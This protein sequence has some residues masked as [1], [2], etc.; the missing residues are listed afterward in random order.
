MWPIA[1]SDASVYSTA[2][3]LTKDRYKRP[4][5]S[6]RHGMYEF[7]LLYPERVADDTIRGFIYQILW[8]VQRWL[9]LPQDEVLLCE[10]DED[11]DRCLFDGKRLL[12]TE[13]NQFKDLSKSI[14]ARNEAVYESIFNFLSSF[15]FHHQ[16]GRRCHFVFTT[17][18]SASTQQKTPE[19]SIDILAAWKKIGLTSPVEDINSLKDAIKGLTSK[20]V[21]K[22][23]SKKDGKLD[24][25]KKIRIT[26]AVDYL[27]KNSLWHPFLSSVSWN[28]QAPDGKLLRADINR[29]LIMHPSLRAASEPVL[30]LFAAR[31]QVEIFHKCANSNPFDRTLIA[32]ER[33]Q[34]LGRSVN[35][36]KLWAQD[37]GLEQLAKEIDL[38]K[39]KFS[40]LQIDFSEIRSRLPPSLKDITD[41]SVKHLARRAEFRIGTDLIRIKRTIYSCIMSW[42]MD[43]HS[44]IVGDPG[45]GKSAVLYQLALMLQAA[46]HDVVVMTVLKF[47]DHFKLADE[48]AQWKGDN[49]GFVLID[50]L[51]AQR[52]QRESLYEAL[53]A[54]IHASPRFHVVVSIRR[55]DLE[56]DLRIQRLFA[57]VPHETYHPSERKRGQDIC[58]VRCFEIRNLDDSE[59]AEVRTQAPMLEAVIQCAGTQLLSLL[60][61]PFNLSIVSQLLSNGMAPESFRSVNTQVKLLDEYWKLR[62]SED[63]V[64]LRTSREALVRSICDGMMKIPDLRL[65]QSA[66][67][68]NPHLDRV[69]DI[70]RAGLLYKSD[71]GFL[72]FNHNII[73]DYAISKYWL[74]GIVIPLDRSIDCQELQA[75]LEQEGDLAMVIYPSLE[76]YFV[77]LW[78]RDLSRHIFWQC[79]ITL[80]ESPLIWPVL[81][82]AP[83][84]VASRLIGRLS[85]IEPLQ[86]ASDSK[87]ISANQTLQRLVSALRNLSPEE[88][89]L[90]G[91]TKRH[92][93]EL[94]RWLSARS[95]P[96]FLDAARRLLLMLTPI[97]T[98][99]SHQY[100]SQIMISAT[101][102]ENQL[103]THQAALAYFDYI[104]GINPPNIELL[105]FSIRILC[106]NAAPHPDAVAVRLRGILAPRMLASYGY[107][108]IPSL[109]RSL[110]WL[111][112]E[113]SSIV[114]EIYT[115][116]FQH[117]GK[118]SEEP[119]RRGGP[120]FGM[121]TN[122]QQDYEGGLHLLKERFG[123]LLQTNPT[124]AT[125][126]LI[127]V[128][129]QRWQA[130]QEREMAFW[131]S[132]DSNLPEPLSEPSEETHTSSPVPAASDE[133]SA[134]QTI[135]HG[136][137][138]TATEPGGTTKLATP[139][140]G[141]PAEPAASAGGPSPAA[142]PARPETPKT[143]AELTSG[144][145]TELV[146]T[147]GDVDLGASAIGS[148]ATPAAPAEFTSSANPAAP[149]VVNETVQSAGAEN[150]VSHGEAVVSEK[151]A[152]SAAPAEVTPGELNQTANLHDSELTGPAQGAGGLVTSSDADSAAAGE[153]TLAESAKPTESAESSVATAP[154]AP[155]IFEDATGSEKVIEYAKH[156][157]YLGKTP[158]HFSHDYS[159]MS[160][161]G[162]ERYEHD[163]DMLNCWT[164]WLDKLISENP[165]DKQINDVLGV[166]FEHNRL[167]RLWMRL[168]RI[169]TRHPNRLG[170]LLLPLARAPY[171]LAAY[172]RQRDVGQFFQSVWHLIEESDRKTIELEIRTLAEGNPGN[173]RIRDSLLK[174]IKGSESGILTSIA[175]SAI[176]P[177]RSNRVQ[178]R[179]HAIPNKASH[180]AAESILRRQLY[181]VQRWYNTVRECKTF[182][183]IP[184]WQI[185]GDMRMLFVELSV[186]RAQSDMDPALVGTA[187]GYLANISRDFVEHKDIE[188]YV[189]LINELECYLISAAQC[190]EPAPAHDEPMSANVPVSW[191]F[192]AARLDAAGGLCA[193]LVR[194]GTQI[195]NDEVVCEIEKLAIYDKN[196]RVRYQI[197]R[198]APY[199][200][201]LF[202]EFAKKYVAY[203]ENNEPSSAVVSE[204]LRSGILWKIF[205][206]EENSAIELLSS[207]QERFSAEAERDIK[208]SEWPSE[209]RL[210]DNLAVN[211]YV[212][213]YIRHDNSL[214]ARRIDEI[215]KQPWTYAAQQIPDSLHRE[216]A[217]G[218]GGWE[219]LS[220]LCESAVSQY[221]RLFSAS[222]MVGSIEASQLLSV[223]QLLLKLARMMW[224]L[225]E[226]HAQDQR[227][228]GE[229]AKVSPRA[230]L[231]DIFDHAKPV[232]KN[233]THIKTPGVSDELI[234]ALS[235]AIDFAPKEALLM[236]ADSLT[237]AISLGY[238]TD[239]FAELTV[240]RFVRRYLTEQRSLLQRDREVR[241]GILKMLSPFVDL[242]W[243]EMQKLVF[244]LADV[245]R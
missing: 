92:W 69:V 38:L 194:K 78:E 223:Q 181:R 163:T 93:C 234:K 240:G 116:A 37:A 217:K 154:D 72:E 192:P 111:L 130:D 236:A 189:G 30:S 20:Y 17:T 128:L 86:C 65:Q 70:L 1:Q 231:Q 137:P 110:S 32:S 188:S 146:G 221:E 85:D 3:T 212:G 214:I 176:P 202:S 169:A 108:I 34:I 82:V 35:E 210:F 237:N 226:A 207:I 7:E 41:W 164:L 120:V 56:T 201:D 97:D 213:C 107:V 21:D 51:D 76:M 153:P 175:P 215:V 144:A 26:S 185:R 46:G 235:G 140:L 136:E 152:P 117:Q 200:F 149:T 157:I 73:F 28:L 83:S 199:F 187:W 48:L 206:K 173:D 219:L 191:G 55:F 224:H 159:S 25:N 53:E 232:L 155:G 218:L 95:E 161:D 184:I 165:Q 16:A 99:R 19:I 168:L 208:S 238:A 245:F 14:S 225:L 87:F 12:S 36:L 109:A 4:A 211:W 59:F 142:E 243:P 179:E 60:Q 106:R 121:Q 43:G 148:E 67:D 75:Q 79:I 13:E 94:A 81:L 220:R 171:V 135:K 167:E 196:S 71:D 40:N 64:A 58:K 133:L 27:D 101:T 52:G 102:L 244:R 166:I 115:A 147:E 100:E 172:E 80:A 11:L 91:S 195:N 143:V 182:T 197:A 193:L 138:A 230:V 57:G 90:W 150:S 190:A 2:T 29:K 127:D 222:P 151:T 18:A 62:I 31:L 139:K 33:D 122:Q 42:I 45:T 74:K 84:A 10:G 141:D 183:D 228:N 88:V 203:I 89:Q 50:G 49:P 170:L 205:H 178:V 119:V 104:I 24:L 123:Y 162:R 180:A 8:T 6:I 114:A 186:P 63:P 233:L 229:H 145:A 47:L 54:A 126:V 209:R 174:F 112:P 124:S 103:D 15:S 23:A 198:Y 44:V 105:E 118:T 242:G 96:S 239:V 177:K 158:V 125:R 216:I 66:L 129:T 131:K 241:A 156:E 98:E 61:N 204:F 113:N 227:R 39:G 68:A 9:E 22:F 134:P 77:H 5:H 132:I 160:D